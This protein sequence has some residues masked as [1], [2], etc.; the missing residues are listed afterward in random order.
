MLLMFAFR[1]FL[2]VTLAFCIAV[3]QES[4]QSEKDPHRPPCTG[5]Q[6]QKVK[7]F[8][9]THYCRRLQGYGADHGCEIRQPT[10]HLNFRILASYNCEGA[11]DTR[12][13]KQQGELSSEL[14]DILVGELRSL[15]LPAKPRGQTYFT[16]WQPIGLDWL[17]VEAYYDYIE[18]SEMRLCQVIAIVGQNSRVF[19]LRKVP[20]QKVDADKNT[21]TTWSPVD[22][23]DVDADGR[24]EIILEGDAYEDRWIE[25]VAMKDSSFRTIFSG[26]G[27]YL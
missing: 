21:V 1:W 13:C 26:L 20:F 22:L 7:S 27:Y 8:V 19:L 16:A 3:G 17:L 25:V 14:R 2:F 11:D 10:E 6:C 18:G 23:A 9:K 12:H 5:A 4:S 24:T 15:G